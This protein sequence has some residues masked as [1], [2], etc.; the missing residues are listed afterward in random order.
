MLRK[1]DS[2]NFTL[3]LIT[4]EPLVNP[5]LQLIVNEQVRLFSEPELQLNHIPLGAHAHQYLLQV[6]QPN[7]L[8]AGT[9]VKYQLLEKQGESVFTSI[10]KLVYPE[11]SSPHFVH[12]PNIK[13]LLHGSCRNPHHPS[14]DGL[15]RAEQQLAASLNTDN[16]PSLL[17]LSGDQVY[18]DDIAGPMLWAI[19][20]VVE[21]LGLI[22]ETFPKAPITS[23]RELCYRASSLYQRD[24]QL[25]PQAEYL[26]ELHLFKWRRKHEIFTSRLSH[27]HLV[28]LGEMIAYYLL[29][30]SPELWKCIEVPQQ[31]EGLS[32]KH[33]AQWQKE[34]RALQTFQHGL[35]SVRRLL[36]HIPTYMIFDDHDVT[37]DWNLSA[38]WEQAAY[39]HPFSKQIIGNALVAYALFQGLGNAPEKLASIQKQLSS[40]FTKPTPETHQNIIQTVLRFEG[41]H[42]ELAT[43][44]KVIV[45]DTRTRRWR[46]ENSLAKPSGLMD[47]EALME[48]QD[49]LIDQEKV[50]IVS[51]A[52]IFGVKLIEAIQRMAT[53][54][55]LSLLVDAENWMA[56]RG[57]AMCLLNMF[58]HRRTPKEFVILSGDVHYSFAYDVKHRCDHFDA[59]IYQ[60]CSSGIKNQFPEKLLPVFDKLN[61]WLYGHYSPLNWF[62]K[63]KRMSLR[64]RR[65][66]GHRSKR[67]V[68][69]SG[70]GLVTLNENG[71]P[72]K[73]A[74]LHSDDSITEFKPPRDTYWD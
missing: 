57:A 63:R 61:G 8:L 37:D 4:R 71:A 5:Q 72:N 69:N 53:F 22:E 65:P 27:N 49:Q 46:S 74:V 15:V 31:L 16:Q 43:S 29:I 55:G 36:A 39:E 34:W 66:N 58:A 6:H 35:T 41:W 11:H 70:I 59:H 56:H 67:L 26:T 60:I 12:K 51:A 44:P 52:P 10:D 14:G 18:I 19:A 62:T 64:G 3:W 20:Q 2:E 48:F 17:M 21:K 73:I 42:Y 50:I 24:S 38:R 30:W 47:W 68:N 28:S 40:F 45:L 13:Q 32:P 7:L 33:Q 9:Q 54:C 23:S 1:C 25:L